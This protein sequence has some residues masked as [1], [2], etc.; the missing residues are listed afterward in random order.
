[1]YFLFGPSGVC[2]VYIPCNSP[3]LRFV[4]LSPVA[5]IYS[6]LRSFAD[7]AFELP[8]LLLDPRRRLLAP[9]RP[10]PL[11]IFAPRGER[12]FGRRV[13]P[14]MHEHPE[15]RPPRARLARHLVMA[16]LVAWRPPA[17]DPA[18]LVLPPFHRPAL[19]A[20]IHDRMITHCYQ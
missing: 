17:D 18:N 12:G 9:Y 11:D 13:L 2:A 4:I 1:M 15:H 3:S 7:R 8:H 16:E 10:R 14:Q 6:S 19:V 20:L 5:G